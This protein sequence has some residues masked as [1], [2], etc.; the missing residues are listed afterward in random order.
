MRGD[1]R[2]ESCSQVLVRVQ[3]L[4]AYT[5]RHVHAH[6]THRN[7]HMGMHIHTCIHID[8]HTGMPMP[9]GT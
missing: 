9:M 5:Q 2:Y 1:I 6:D 7:L 3:T 8:M 4:C